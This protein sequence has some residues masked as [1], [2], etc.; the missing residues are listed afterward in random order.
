[1]LPWVVVAWLVL[2]GLY[3]MVTSRNLVHLVVC[4]S[5]MQSATFLLLGS[6]AYRRGLGPA[7]FLHGQTGP[8]ADPVLHALA[9]VDI[10]V[11]AAVTALLLAVAVEV[12]R[13][14]GTLDPDELRATD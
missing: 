7:V 5:V 1:M 9:L 4:L 6:L 3:G 10:V 2:A 8:A 14:R 11:D 12:L 13:H